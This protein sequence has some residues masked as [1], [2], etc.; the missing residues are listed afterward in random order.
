MKILTSWLREFVDL[1]VDDQTLARDLTMAG[2]AV[3]GMEKAGN[4]TVFSMEITT[5]RPDAMNH[6]GVAREAAAIYDKPLKPIVAVFP[7]SKVETPLRASQA[8]PRFKIAI[9]DK[10]G[11]ARYTSRIIRGVR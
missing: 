10:A 9:E 3:E 2:I 5:N 4:D 8:Q 6:Y 11:C 7:K 1:K